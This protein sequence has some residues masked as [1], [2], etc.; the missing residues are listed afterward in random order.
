MMLHAGI[1]A[2]GFNSNCQCDIDNFSSI[3]APPSAKVKPEQHDPKK[4]KRKKRPIKQPKKGQKSKGTVVTN[5]IPK[6]P[7]LIHQS[8]PYK[9]YC[10]YTRQL[11]QTSQRSRGWRKRNA[12]PSVVQTCFP[13]F[14]YSQINQFKPLKTRQLQKSGNA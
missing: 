12:S 11:N 4:K 6:V 2:F 14:G 9:F 13:T 5:C 1:L 10:Q 7:C 8:S 3:S